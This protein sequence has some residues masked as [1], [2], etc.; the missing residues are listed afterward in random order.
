MKE[1][2][3][4]AVTKSAVLVALLCFLQWIIG[5]TESFAGPYLADSC[6]I[7]ILA[8]AA[9]REDLKVS[10]SA[11][12]L[13]PFCAYFLG[14][15]AEILQIVPAIALGDCVLVVLLR[16]L[17]GQKGK[18]PVQKII[19]VAVSALVRFIVLYC[20]I[21][22][23]TIPVMGPA[24]PAKQAAVIRAAYSWPQLV[25]ALIGT[26]AAVLLCLLIKKFSKK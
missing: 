17:G 14:I 21:I 13:F 8:M 3:M 22:K 2:V 23:V 19:S 15:G 11:A 16:L 5:Y 20:A 1:K 12:V 4:Q 24:L 10:V 6:I 26:A 7:C 9:L 18:S 25:T